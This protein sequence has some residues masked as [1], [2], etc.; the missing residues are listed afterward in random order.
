MTSKKLRCVVI[1][2]EKQER[3]MLCNTLRDYEA[4]DIV[5]EEESVEDAYELIKKVQPDV[6][7]LDIEIIGGNAFMLLKMLEENKVKMPYVVITTGH[8][9]YAVRA[10]NDYSR[11]VVKYIM[12]PYKGSEM[13]AKFQDAIEALQAVCENPNT[14]NV[15]TALGQGE[16]IMLRT[17]IGYTTIHFQKVKFV[18]VEAKGSGKIQIMTDHLSDPIDMTLSKI[19]KSLPKNIVQISKYQAVNINFINGINQGDR[20]LKLEGNSTAFGIGNNYY[21]ELLAVLPIK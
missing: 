1:E 21:N 3:K 4:I 11:Y 17:R 10:I 14:A 18:S 20:T 16:F 9:D 13:N 6:A 7:F 12:K 8:I 2:D 15:A 5:G 19:L